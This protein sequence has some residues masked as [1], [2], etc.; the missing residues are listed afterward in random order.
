MNQ[1]YQNYETMDENIWYNLD[2]DNTKKDP[3]K[4]IFCIRCKRKLKETQSFESFFSV[5]LHHENYWVRLN[6]KGGYLL[7]SECAKKLEKVPEEILKKY[8]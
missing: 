5:E 3:D 4:G 6:I 1:T 8:E 7:G 2:P